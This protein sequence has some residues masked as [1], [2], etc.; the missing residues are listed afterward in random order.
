MDTAAILAWFSDPQNWLTVIGGASA[1]AVAL[2]N[3]LPQLE[4]WANSTITNADNRFV[5]NL[6]ATLSLFTAF[7][8]VAHKVVSVIALNPI[9]KTAAATSPVHE[10]DDSSTDKS[11]DG[12][13]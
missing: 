6:G 10:E 2:R 12:G 8:D 4:Q 13:L 7:L 3:A 5:E 1:I 11:S 9:A